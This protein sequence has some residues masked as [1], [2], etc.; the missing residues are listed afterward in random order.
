MKN[1]EKEKQDSR[2]KT[3][4]GQ[5]RV[6]TKNFRSLMGEANERMKGQQLNSIRSIYEVLTPSKINKSEPFIQ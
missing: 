2:V 5:S 4:K 1:D 3:R 6:E